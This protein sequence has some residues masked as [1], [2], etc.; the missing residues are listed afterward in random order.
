MCNAVFYHQAG[1]DDD[2]DGEEED[3]GVKTLSAP[4]VIPLLTLQDVFLQRGTKEI[5]WMTLY[6]F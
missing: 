1:N 4:H 5:K 2:K 6:L 3:N